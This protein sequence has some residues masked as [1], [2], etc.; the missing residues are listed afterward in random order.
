MRKPTPYSRRAKLF[1]ILVA[2]ASATLAGL[3]VSWYHG[4]SHRWIRIVSP[5]GE[6]ATEIL[7]VNRVM[8][9]YVKTQQGNLYFCS[10]NS[11]RDACQ[12]ITPAALPLTRIHPKWQTCPPPFPETPPAPGT[13]VDAV[14][15]GQCA[16]ARTYS[17]VILLSDGS[18]WL[19]RRTYSWVEPFT[20]GTAALL[21][22]LLG[23]GFGVFFINTRRYLR[24]P[25]PANAK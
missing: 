16:E 21:G 7:A 14:E 18:L 12:P 23:W 25:V 24:T 4:R 19:W 15:A 1:L 3:A 8:M 17:K 13:I 20:V 10:G 2:L 6:T 22:L 5:K 9:P 11:W